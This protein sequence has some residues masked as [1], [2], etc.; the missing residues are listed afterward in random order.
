MIVDRGSGAGYKESASS[1][2]LVRQNSPTRTAIGPH[3]SVNLTEVMSALSAVFPTMQ[4]FSE[5][6]RAA[7][8]EILLS[9]TASLRKEDSWEGRVAVIDAIRA[10]LLMPMAPLISSPLKGA[11][12]RG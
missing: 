9:Q 11:V 12:C 10:M 3:V 7:I 2:K 5:S 6:L 4:S 8:L 1:A